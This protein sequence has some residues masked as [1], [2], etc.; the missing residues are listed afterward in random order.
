ME[1]QAGSTRRE[2]LELTLSLIPS[3]PAS[4]LNSA[5]VGFTVPVQT[6]KGRFRYDKEGRVIGCVPSIT[7]CSGLLI[8]AAI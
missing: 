3:A 8:F 1:G 2:G 4:A 6:R 7:C 5:S